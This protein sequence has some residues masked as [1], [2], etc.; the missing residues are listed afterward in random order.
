MVI[1]DACV[2]VSYLISTAKV[3]PRLLDG[4][5]PG[6]FTIGFRPFHWHS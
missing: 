2:F 6:R 5:A 4:P 3:T 1:V